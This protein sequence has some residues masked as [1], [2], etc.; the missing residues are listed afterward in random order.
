MKR[1]LDT[2]SKILLVVFNTPNEQAFHNI[3]VNYYKVFTLPSVS[4]GLFYQLIF[5]F[6]KTIMDKILEQTGVIA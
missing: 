1:Y 4:V 3:E 5:P 2:F 6:Q